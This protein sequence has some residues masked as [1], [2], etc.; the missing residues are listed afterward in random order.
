MR[1]LL[2]NLGIRNTT[3]HTCFH[4]VPGV[5][6]S[7]SDQSP[8]SVNHALPRNIKHLSKYGKHHQRH[9]LCLIFHYT[10]AECLHCVSLLEKDS[11]ACLQTFHL[12][13]IFSLF[14]VTQAEYTILR[15]QTRPVE[16]QTRQFYTVVLLGR[17]GLQRVTHG[18]DTT[19]CQKILNFGIFKTKSSHYVPFYAKF[20]AAC[21]QTRLKYFYSTKNYN[22]KPSG[23]GAM[24]HSYAQHLH[25]HVHHEGDALASAC[26]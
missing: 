6:H 3:S 22:K 23:N 4:H 19:T 16:D 15:S 1:W 8:L 13:Q 9:I 25:F 7:I 21:N 26:R 5:S 2:H 12:C 11:S 20:H 17:C 10:Q 18:S 14:Y 24:L